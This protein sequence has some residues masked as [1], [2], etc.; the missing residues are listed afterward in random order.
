[1]LAFPTISESL[2]ADL[3]SAIWIILLYLLVVAV[4]TTQLGRLGD[5]YGR[6][7]MLRECGHRTG[8]RACPCTGRAGFPRCTPG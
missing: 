5:I 2:H 8:R 4:C 3:L 1:M 7:R 6:S